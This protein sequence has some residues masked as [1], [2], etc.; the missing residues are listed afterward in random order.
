MKND[1]SFSLRQHVNRQLCRGAVVTILSIASSPLLANSFPGTG[2]QEVREVT[3]NHAATQQ[4][5]KIT[6][7]V[8]DS[9]GE[10]LPGAAVV[11]Q[12]TPQGVTTDIDGNFS[13]E[14]GSNASLEISY[15]GMETKVVPVS[16]IRRDKVVRLKEKTDEL[17]E[18]TVVAFAKQKKESVLASVT[19]VKP[20]ELKAPTSNLTTALAGRVAGLISYQRSGEPGMDNADFFVRGVTTFG[21]AKSPLILMDGLEIT[22]SD[23]SRL[24]PDDIASFSIMKDATATALYGARGAN[25]VILVTTKEGKEGRAKVEFRIENSISSPTRKVELADPVTYMELRNEAFRTRNPLGGVPYS[26]EKIA[27]TIAGTNPYMY[28]A[29][30]WYSLMMK[31]AVANQRYNLNLSGGGTVARYYVAATFNQDHGL[32]KVD[33]RNNFNNNINVKRYSIRSNV[34]INVTKTTKMVVRLYTTI[35]DQTGPIDGG[36]TL[37]NK[38]MQTSPVEFPAYYPQTRGTEHIQHIM[39]GNSYA[40]GTTLYI[41]PYADMVKGYKDKSASKILAQFEVNQD[42]KFITKGL[43]ARALFST[44]RDSSFDVSRFYNPFYYMAGNYNPLDDSYVLAELNP[45]GGTEYLGYDEGDKNISTNTYMEAA[46]NYDRTFNEKHAVSGMLI[47]TLQNRL[48]ANASSLQLSLPYRNMGLSGR[49]TYSYDSRYFLEANFGYNGSERFADNERFGFFPSVGLGY[50]MS[51]EKFYKGWITKVIPNLKWKATYGLVGNDA[52]GSDEDRFFYLSEVNMD[53]KD[54]GYTF[55]SEYNTSKN[56]ISIKRY[57]NPYIT[58]E[59]AKKLNVGAEF[60]LLNAV[61]VQIDY[62]REKRSN[63]LQ[64]RAGI[65]STMGLQAGVRANV[66]EAE[67]SGLDMSAD[68]N[69]SFNKDLWMQGRFNFTYAT[70]NVTKYEENDYSKTPWRSR[71]G[72]PISQQWG[73]VAERLFVDEQDIA[74]SPTQFGDYMAGDIK[75]KDINNDG[76]I[77]EA[78]QVPI[79]FPTSPEIVYGFGLSAGYKG[80]DVSCFFQ[81]LARES[82]WLNVG[83]KKGTTHPFIDDTDLDGL[84][85]NQ[86]LQAYADNHWS[87]NN[88]NLYALW[89]RLSNTVISNNNRTSTWF[90]QDGSFLRLKSVEVGYS[91]PQKLIKK[92]FM[93]RLRIYYSGTN[94]LSFSKFDLWDPE[95]AG[96]GL[97]YP[98]QRVHNIGIQVAF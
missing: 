27:N 85:Q 30:D 70:S 22:S 55:G 57:A 88:R 32:M 6:G 35:E 45:D 81:G 53:N 56:G 19:A 74:N 66:G 34:N 13:I 8:I 69:Y 86:L 14:V 17:E 67:S 20:A 29:T 26:Q 48:N 46:V 7:R 49:F 64:D 65:P 94:L 92:M 98:I 71:V 52:I 12:G 93:S 43:K 41:N 33:K 11:I 68:Y 42:L 63:I 91:F 3:V 77:S 37:Y 51:N 1:T 10:P 31:D 23:L 95:M 75:Y 38:I 82:F 73:Y 76:I 80:L 89:P 5:I 54:Y 58:W 15:L 28:P 97:G 24:Q 4:K 21:Y 44:T 25:G 50:I 96:N 2:V 47:F 84:G 78:D 72:H 87:E 83:N 9:V 61:D 36:T 62:F 39:F 79:G 16:V 59:I 60:N 18:V 90:M 40:E